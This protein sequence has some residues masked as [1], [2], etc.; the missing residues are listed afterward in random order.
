MYANNGMRLERGYSEDDI[1]QFLESYDFIPEVQTYGVV[2]DRFGF[3]ISL[4]TDW[5]THAPYDDGFFINCRASF[6]DM[7]VFAEYDTLPIE[8]YLQADTVA[9]TS[10]FVFDNGTVGWIINHHGS[11]TRIM[12]RSSGHYV[13][14]YIEYEAARPWFIE[15]REL[16]YS[17]ART[18]RDI[19]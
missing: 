2:N 11:V 15:N 4:P 9:N 16:V 10:E 5:E 6:V 17:L 14:F 13:T 1:W 19:W 18:L 7:R 12:Y 3:V 8:H